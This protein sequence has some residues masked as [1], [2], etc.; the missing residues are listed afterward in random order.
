[1]CKHPHNQIKVYQTNHRHTHYSQLIGISM[2]MQSHLIAPRSS[3]QKVPCIDQ[4]TI[5]KKCMCKFYLYH[6]PSYLLRIKCTYYLATACMHASMT[7][8]YI[9]IH[10]NLLSGSA[11]LNLTLYHITPTLKVANLCGFTTICS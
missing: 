2:Y 10:F 9:G 4:V 6:I 3:L 5:V 8:M 1:M 11:I 7:V